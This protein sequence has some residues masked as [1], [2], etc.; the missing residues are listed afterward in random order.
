MAKE[1]LLSRQDAK[2]I[3]SDIPN[4]EGVVICKKTIPGKGECGYTVS[5]LSDDCF[6]IESY[7]D[8]KSY[9]SPGVID[10]FLFEGQSKDAMIRYLVEQAKTCFDNID[11]WAADL[12]DLDESEDVMPVSNGITL[13]QFMALT[14]DSVLLLIDNGTPIFIRVGEDDAFCSIDLSPYLNRE[15]ANIKHTGGAIELRVK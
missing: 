12:D 15:I 8:N 1:Y 10:T 13:G 11:G 2:L 3:V 4:V 14:T 9:E 5:V 6:V 7:A